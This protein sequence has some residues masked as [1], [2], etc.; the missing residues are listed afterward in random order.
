[1]PSEAETEGKGSISETT[2]K[3]NEIIDALARQ[4][5]I[6]RESRGRWLRFVLGIQ[7]DMTYQIDI[8]HGLEDEL[9]LQKKLIQDIVDVN[10][11]RSVHI[12]EAIEELHGLAS[13]TLELIEKMQLTEDPKLIPEIT[14][15]N[16][17]F[18]I[19]L[20]NYIDYLETEFKNWASKGLQKFRLVLE[21]RDN[22]EQQSPY[23]LKAGN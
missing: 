15:S 1:L 22:L 9:D 19:N 18:K 2:V 10:P 16:H 17:D 21:D 12:P 7:K 11:P 13:R 20:F 3:L 5:D 14:S 8:F 23:V 4:T 6:V